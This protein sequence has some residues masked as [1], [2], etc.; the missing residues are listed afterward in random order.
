MESLESNQRLLTLLNIQYPIIQAP[1]GG[2]ATPELAAAVSNAG[3][4]GGLALSWSTPE[5]AQEAIESLKAK[6]TKP[7]YVNFA[8]NF[9]PVALQKCIALGVSSI[10]FSW[11]MPNEE[12][13]RL[14]KT[15]GV[16][17]GIQVTNKASAALAISLGA[18]YLVCQG[19]EAGGH[20][21]AS[22]PLASSLTEVLEEAGNIPVVA[23][24]G[25]SSG[26]D[27]AKYLK[28][29][30]AGVVMGSRFVATQESGAHADYKE[31][32][33]KSTYEDTVLTVCMNKGWDNAIH[34]ILK[35]S[36]HSTWEAS[37][38]PQIGDRPGE[39]DVLGVNQNGESI[40]RYSFDSPQNGVTGNTE[41]MALYA[42]LSV[43]HITDIPIVNE[44]IQRV[45]TEYCSVIEA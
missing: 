30:A 1:V 28:L 22:T 29:G 35:N 18:D 14:I 31:R 36:T 23:S 34:R 37:G 39:L 24:G 8:L 44:V 40:E 17:M 3:A 20:V 16:I 33:V 11:G 10:Q 2:I 7:F 15:N 21:Q 5:Q 45:W 4:F 12:T 9:K 32:L 41:A 42:G 43:K 26:E 25:I 6:T 13:I 38:C 27:L 19:V